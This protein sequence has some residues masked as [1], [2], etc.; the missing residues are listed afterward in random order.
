MPGYNNFVHQTVLGHFN[1]GLSIVSLSPACCCFKLLEMGFR[2]GLESRL[3]FL[4]WDLLTTS[5][6]ICVTGYIA[7]LDIN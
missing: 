2:L 3:E 7:E 5:A 1:N 4:F 6:E